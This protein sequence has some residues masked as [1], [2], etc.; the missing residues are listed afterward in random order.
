MLKAGT[1]RLFYFTA[2]FNYICDAFELV[3]ASSTSANNRAKKPLATI[4][5]I[6]ENIHGK[7]NSTLHFGF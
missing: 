2:D 6:I 3:V 1:H 7:T 4:E 5:I